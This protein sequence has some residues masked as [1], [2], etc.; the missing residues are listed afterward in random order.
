MSQKRL[1]VYLALL[2]TSI[3]WGLAPPI[4]KYTLNYV[5]YWTFLFYRFFFASIIL[6]LP[7]FFRILKTRPQ[8]KDWPAYF[9]LGFL[10]TPL[11]LVLLFAGIAKTTASDA[12]VISVISPML[13]I[14]G[15]IL[16]LKEK[17]SK[18]EQK[19]ILLILTGAFLTIIQPLLVKNS[20]R[21]DQNVLGNILVFLGA[22]DW[23]VF[24]LLAKNKKLDPFILTAVSFLVGLLFFLPSALRSW[25][26]LALPALPGIFYMVVFCSIIAYFTYLYGLSKIPV[27]EAEIFTYLQIVFA[28]PASV[29]FL[30]EEISLVFILGA[31]LIITGVIVSEVR[32]HQLSGL[33]QQTL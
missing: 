28:I 8:I 21:T 13:V 11:N 32:R 33:N 30:H 9:F 14:M 27:S 31:I 25:P 18:S 3:F 6:I 4:I 23:A 7:L 22:L 16:F 20:P 10:A 19:G 26:K 29:I 1:T 2:I 12:A 15:G 24:T 17:I 5:S